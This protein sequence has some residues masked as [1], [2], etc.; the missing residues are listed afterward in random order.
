[1][2]YLRYFRKER[3]SDEAKSWKIYDVGM[4][5]DDSGSFHGQP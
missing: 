4:C 3:E 1:M 2:I 5:T